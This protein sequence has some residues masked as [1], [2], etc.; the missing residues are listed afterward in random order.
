M[1]KKI[2]LLIVISFFPIYFTLAS[3][4]INEIMYDL[5]TG[6]DEG[7]E[8]IEVFNN[9]DSEVDLSIL[10]LFEGDTN[11]KLT[12]VEGSTKI[13]P[14]GYAIIVSNPSKFAADWP[15]FFG[16]IFD[17][18]FSLNNAGEVLA[19][20]DG[21]KIID[22]YAYKG[23]TSGAGDGNSL[24]R[25]N[26]VWVGAK[27]TPGAENQ[28]SY[29]SASLLT[30][31]TTKPASIQPKQ[32]MLPSGI[33]T[34]PTVNVTTSNNADNSISFYILVTTLIFLLGIG[35]RT[36]YLIRSKKVIAKEGEDF[37]LLEE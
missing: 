11:H 4:E 29:T 7:R 17:S 34:L 30:P 23:S 25:I 5:K 35:I 21:D 15:N 18:T 24:K 32:A 37:E 2:I 10:K 22:Q 36:V 26:N 1:A 33:D 3:L 13:E 14:A 27:P 31:K 16:T 6:S 28:I 20:K 9:S 19:L 8:W 12:L